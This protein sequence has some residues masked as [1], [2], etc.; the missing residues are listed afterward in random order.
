LEQDCDA[1]VVRPAASVF[2][3][4]W[5]SASRPEGIEVSSRTGWR[6]MDE[7]LPSCMGPPLVAATCWGSGAS[8]LGP[9]LAAA[10]CGRD[11]SCQGPPQ[12]AASWDSG[13]S[14]LGL[15]LVAATWGRGASSL[16][17]PWDAA[18]WGRGGSCCGSRGTYDAWI[19]PVWTAS[20]RASWQLPIFSLMP[21][22]KV[23]A[24]QVRGRRYMEDLVR[25]RASA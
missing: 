22:C 20:R 1:P 11:A 24:V 7:M 6:G 14:S 16:G 4:P 18:T 3:G 5:L 10:T 17:P 9:P 23:C 21:G 13:A 15:P 8:F 2:G 12:A 25:N 19:A